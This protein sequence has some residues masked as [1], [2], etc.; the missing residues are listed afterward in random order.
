MAQLRQ[1]VLEYKAV[2][3]TVRKQ[4]SNGIWS[5]NILGLGP[6]KAQG[7]ADVGTVAQYRH[8]VEL[9]VPQ[10]QRP[11]RLAE[12]LF[13]RIL[14][15]DDDP[16]LL[17]EHQKAARTNPLLGKWARDQYREGVTAAL[18]HGGKNED[19]RVRGSAHKILNNVSQFLRSEL[20]EKP[21]VRKGSRNILHP[22]AN[23]PTLFAV[24]SVAFM[25][26]LQRERAGFMERLGTFLTKPATKR[27]YVIQL[28]RKVVQPR[29][30]LLGDPLQAD[31]AGHP[32]DLPFALHW[33]ELLTRLHM[34]EN[35]PV[36]VR[37]LSR[38][39]KMC[40]ERGVWS[41]KNLRALPKSAS[42]IA[43]FAFPLEA[44]TR[45][46]QSRK[47]DVTFRLALIAKLAGRDLEYT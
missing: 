4:R 13:Y 36:A 14:S 25:P 43:A 29:F 5:A 45:S 47:A 35:S 19:P 23:P 18:A 10:N 26:R 31:S 24:T 34:L 17:F 21:I 46:Q 8:L 22:A 12:R 1:E 2:K 11:Y 39:L 33:L 7:I 40:D 42:G 3:Q 44:D 6:S 38:L 27:T 16:A 20:A 41:P 15:R 28:G 32:K 37:I 30:Q 9:G